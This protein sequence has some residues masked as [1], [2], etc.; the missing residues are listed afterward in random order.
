MRS[1]VRVHQAE[2]RSRQVPRSLP[3]TGEPTGEPTASYEATS[4]SLLSLTPLS[5]AGHRIFS[6]G[7]ARVAAV[8]AA[9]P[10][11][12]TCWAKAP[13]RHPSPPGRPGEPILAARR[14]FPAGMRPRSC[15][16]S[17][18][19][20]CRIVRIR[21]SCGWERAGPRLPGQTRTGPQDF[22]VVTQDRQWQPPGRCSCPT[23]ANGAN[24]A[25]RTTCEQS[26][27]MRAYRCRD[28]ALR[29]LAVGGVR[30]LRLWAAR[31]PWKALIPS[32][33]WTWCSA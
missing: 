29:S 9:V 32:A 19:S 24:G 11:S 18:G 7:A 16:C 26:A 10:L 20:C 17:T 28:A 25:Q 13:Q 30:D 22:R 3:A 21:K 2:L 14:Q 8:L 1:R 12:Q 33:D 23:W 5:A 31:V 6:A 15:T 4:S 27:V